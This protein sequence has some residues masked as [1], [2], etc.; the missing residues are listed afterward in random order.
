M[1]KRLVMLPVLLVVAHVCFPT[2]SEASN[3][4]RNSGA[5]ETQ[6]RQG[7]QPAPVAPAAIPQVGSNTTFNEFPEGKDGKDGW[8]VAAVLSN[9]LLVVIGIGGIVVGV[10][11]LRKLERQT[12]ATENAAMSSLSQSNHM[13]TS[14][15]AW[16]VAEPRNPVIPPEIKGATGIGGVMFSIRFVNRGETPA[17]LME[18]GF[19]GK[20]LPSSEQLPP[21]Q[22]PYESEEVIKWKGKGLPILKGVDVTRDNLIT[23]ANDPVQIARGFDVFWVYGYIKYGDAFGNPIETW[24]C[25]RWVHEIENYQVSGFI[26]GGPESYNRAT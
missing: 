8:D 18:V 16:M 11:T 1:L 20:V 12:K 4:K 10:V 13:I 21:V 3:P 26:A 17:Y 24:Y 14:Q 25:Y 6:G 5:N 23:W 7:Q 19:R 22:P 9:Y 2:P 15:R